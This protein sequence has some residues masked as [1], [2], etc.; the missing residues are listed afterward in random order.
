MVRL[1][2][3]LAV[4]VMA[5][6]GC[7]DTAGGSAVPTAEAA[8]EAAGPLTA[9]QAL[10]D[11]ASVDYCGLLDATPLPADV[12]VAISAP[13]RSSEYCQFKVRANGFEVE[14]RVGYLHDSEAMKSVDHTEDRSKTP[15]RGLAIERGLENSDSCGR[16]LRF[17]DNMW[18]T[19][20]AVGN[21]LGGKG[22]W[23][24]VADATV[25]AVIRHVIAK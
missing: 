2:A 24:R 1:L 15:P 11:S 7:A 22:D 16:Y 5:M 17:T 10:G 14:V 4:L 13:S 9:K 21:S 23:C 18:L 25:D 19:I 8:K 12:A 20:G 6:G 3:A